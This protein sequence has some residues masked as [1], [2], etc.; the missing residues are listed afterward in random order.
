MAA[1]ESILHELTLTFTS[2]PRRLCQFLLYKCQSRG[3]KI[4]HPAKA[5]SV[6]SDD[7]DAISSICIQNLKT[8]EQFDISCTRLLI[9]AGV[10]SPQVFKMLFPTSKTKIP[11]TSLA[12]HS[13]IVSSPRWQMHDEANGCHAIFTTD[14]QG[15]SPE[16]FSRT[17]G[18]IYV[19]GLNSETI[20]IP[21]TAQDAEIDDESLAALR[22]TAKRLLGLPKTDDLVE[23]RKGLCFRPITRRGTPFLSR[24]DDKKLGGVRTKGGSEGGVYIAAGHGPWGISLG[25]GSGKVMSEMLMGTRPSAD[26]SGLRL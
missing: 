1:L 5:V 8:N 16:V 18:E 4:H 23:I 6:G 12:G 14:E 22:V 9:A 19:A 26:V 7:R 25:L 10:W 17:G 21:K 15:Y 2:D 11:V 20:P 24:I 3:V 13:L